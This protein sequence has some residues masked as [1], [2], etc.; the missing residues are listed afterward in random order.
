VIW[1]LSIL[2]FIS[3]LLTRMIKLSKEKEPINYLMHENIDNRALS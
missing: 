3:A 2:Y 1:V